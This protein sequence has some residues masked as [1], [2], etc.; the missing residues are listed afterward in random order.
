M[1][2]TRKALLEVTFLA[3]TFIYPSLQQGGAWPTS[4]PQNYDGR[5][6]YRNIKTVAVAGE[7]CPQALADDWAQ[8][9]SFWN[10][11]GSTETFL[12][13]AQE[14]TVGKPLSVGRPLPNT[15]CYVLDNAGR[16]APVGQKGS[17]WV[18]GAGVAKGYI[19]LP[20]TTAEKFQFDKF[21][22]DGSKMFDFGNIVS[23]RSDGTIDS[24]GRM[25]DQIK[26]KGFRV[27]LEGVAAT[28]E[29]RIFLL[30]LGL[31]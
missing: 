27:E 20:L 5:Q 25:D 26:I 6:R 2:S 3:L 1:E 19:N 17:L 10:L 15:S 23:W 22:H 21:A 12:V 31:R 8:G 9:R 16:L 24:F 14:H 29:V 18:G 13:S 7:A 4:E 28:V 30:N 11:L